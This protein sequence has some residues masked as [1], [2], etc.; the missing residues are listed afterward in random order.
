MATVTFP[1][2]LTSRLLKEEIIKKIMTFSGVLVQSPLFLRV[3]QLRYQF[4]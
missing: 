3:S 4:P 1:S 2:D